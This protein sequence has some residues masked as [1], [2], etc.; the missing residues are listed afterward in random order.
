[1]LL[2]YPSGR[3]SLASPATSFWQ[4]IIMMYLASYAYLLTLSKLC[5]QNIYT[6]FKNYLATQNGTVLFIISWVLVFLEFLGVICLLINP[7]PD[8]P[9]SIMMGLN[10][11]ILAYT[12]LVRQQYGDVDVSSNSSVKSILGT[13][14]NQSS[15]IKE[16]L[17]RG[18]NQNIKDFIIIDENM[19]RRSKN[20]SVQEIV[21]K[22]MTASVC[23]STHA[24]FN[25]LIILTSAQALFEILYYPG[26]QPGE[27]FVTINH[28]GYNIRMRTYCTGPPS[29]MKDGIVTDPMMLIESGLG[30]SGHIHYEIQAA[31]QNKYTVCTYDRAGFGLSWIGKY[32]TYYLEMMEQMILAMTEINIPILEQH[33]QIICIGHS[34]GGQ[35]CQMYAKYLPSIR[36]LVLLDTYPIQRVYNLLNLAKGMSYEESQSDIWSQVAANRLTAL[37]SPLGIVSYLAYQSYY[38]DNA[39]LYMYQLFWQYTTVRQQYAQYAFKHYDATYCGIECSL[40]AISQHQISVPELVVSARNPYQ[41]CSVIGV[42]SYSED[43]AIYIKQRDS[44]L[45]V[46]NEM[47]KYT[48]GWSKIKYCQGVCEHDFAYT[49]PDFVILTIFNNLQYL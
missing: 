10:F 31:Y 21:V 49:K 3:F 11:I 43:C 22:F 41:G 17:E 33:A 32:P 1:M 2:Y 24:I 19:P 16:K 30:T 48:S 29:F 35:L 27:K 18:N 28:N 12:L 45:L 40:K 37:F 20:S 8:V 38:F 42:K 5:H 23:I 9:G 15:I 34:L 4:A 26:G 36:S 13:S 25:F 46:Q 44:L 47:A 39:P 14:I 7:A 6:F